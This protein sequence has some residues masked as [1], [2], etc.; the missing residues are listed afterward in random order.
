MDDRGNDKCVKASNWRM[1]WKNSF[2]LRG[3]DTRRKSRRYKAL[4]LRRAMS[5]ARPKL[6]C[7]AV[8]NR[9]ACRDCLRSLATYPFF[10]DW[11]RALVQHPMN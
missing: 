5:D 6:V 11:L 8:N 9:S 7:G 4:Q 1:A 10:P 2:K 3:L